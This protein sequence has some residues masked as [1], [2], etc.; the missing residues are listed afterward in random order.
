M[1]DD[2]QWRARLETKLDHVHAVCHAILD[3]LQVIPGADAAHIA[4]ITAALKQQ[5]ASLQE[6]VDHN[7]VPTD[8]EK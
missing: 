5:A 3:A 8:P 4:A 6:A 1:R 2:Q 7:P